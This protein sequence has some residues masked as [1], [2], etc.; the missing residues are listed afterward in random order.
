MKFFNRLQMSRVLPIGGLLI[1][2]CYFL[3]I[4]RADEAFPSKPIKL[5]VPF[6]PGGATDVIGRLMAQKLSESLK[7]AV[8]V[9]NKPG[10]GSVLGT[11][12]AAKSAPDGYTWVMTNGSAIT[13]GPLLRQS[14]PYKA[15]DDFAHV[16]VIGTFPNAFVVRTESP[17]KSFAEFVAH[18]RSNPG[19]LNYSSA[20]IG[21]AGY[22]TGEMLKQIGQLNMTHVAYKGTGPATIDLLGGQIDALFDGVPTAITQA[23]AGK[24]RL[25]AVTG[26][27]RIS[28]HPDL[29]TMNEVLPG[30]IGEAWFG[31][32]APAK[33][34]VAILEKMETELMRIVAASDVQ[35]KL[36]DLGMSPLSLGR[37][38]STAFIRADT[39]RWEPIIK[40]ANI[41]ID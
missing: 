13:T 27:K 9:D 15:M 20:G 11:D 25:L 19:K 34:P 26:A 41:K 12:F 10:A 6:A 4:A 30:V 39:N 7:M 35:T 21:S 36:I 18:A 37:K 28:S 33:T 31:L 24:V 38:D 8:I 40:T 32:S 5:V 16:F 22:L 23:K 1:L 2:L 17:I 3:Q 14:M 29:P